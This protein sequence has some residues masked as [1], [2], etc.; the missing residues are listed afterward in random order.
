MV[1]RSNSMGSD[2]DKVKLNNKRTALQ[3][4][5]AD[6]DLARR[7]LSA[8]PLT[9]DQMVGP[10][11]KL[12]WMGRMSLEC[13]VDVLCAHRLVKDSPSYAISF[14][15]LGELATSCTV[16]YEMFFLE[17]PNG[18]SE[19]NLWFKLQQQRLEQKNEGIPMLPK[20]RFVRPFVEKHWQN[21]FPIPAF[22]GFEAYLNWFGV[23][24]CTNC[25]MYLGT[26]MPTDRR[27]DWIPVSPF[28][29]MTAE[30][31]EVASKQEME[32]FDGTEPENWLV[33]AQILQQKFPSYYCCI[34]CSHRLDQHKF[35]IPLSIVYESCLLRSSGSRKGHLWREFDTDIYTPDKTLILTTYNYCCRCGVMSISEEQHEREEDNIP[36]C[37]LCEEQEADCDCPNCESC[38]L[39][40][41]HCSC[42]L[43][44]SCDRCQADDC[45]EKCQTNHCQCDASSSEDSSSSSSSSGS[46]GF[47]DSSDSD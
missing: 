27:D 9:F 7:E 28:R 20:F 11:E 16:L 41:I 44:A 46:S 40:P 42:I 30:E 29:L 33:A 17:T 25:S 3:Q 12:P 43:C 31:R 2:S 36:T 32:F 21:G 39:A 14:T 19:N 23:G 24:F 5:R 37:P 8:P 15:R 1:K 35:G 10:E 4:F 26:Q 34:Q 22:S 6:A 38:D 47:D 13:L 18:G 45:S